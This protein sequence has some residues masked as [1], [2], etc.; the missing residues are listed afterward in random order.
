MKIAL[1]SLYT[2]EH[3]VLNDITAESKSAY[4]ARWGYDFINHFGST[5]AGSG[6]ASPDQ[7]IRILSDR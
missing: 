4:A 5:Q 3:S 2:T 1:V 6:D 7:A